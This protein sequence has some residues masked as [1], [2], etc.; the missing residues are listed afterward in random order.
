[1]NRTNNPVAAAAA[2]ATVTESTN[3]KASRGLLSAEAI[4]HQ[5]SLKR[6]R[7]YEFAAADL[8]PVVRRGQRMW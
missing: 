5:L 8:L 6:P 1:M 2:A 3:A 7:V 4:G